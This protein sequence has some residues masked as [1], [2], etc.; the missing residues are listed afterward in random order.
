MEQVFAY[1]IGLGA[2]VMMPII[3][4]VLGVCIGNKFSNALK[5]GLY[6]G[7]GFVGLSVITGLLTSSLGPALAKVVEIYGL[8]LNVFD[9]GWP[10]AASVAY[11]TTVGAFIIPVC[12]GVNLLLLLL[13]CTRTVNIDLWNYWHFAFIGAVVF[14]L[15]DSLFHD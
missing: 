10:A 14:F 7:V 8:E 3:F 12:L 6:V 11:N 2:A 4:T 15:T 1:I 13:G 5:S 9:M